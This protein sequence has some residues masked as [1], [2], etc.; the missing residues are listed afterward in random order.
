MEWMRYLIQTPDQKLNKDS[1]I[2]RERVRNREAEMKKL[3]MSEPSLFLSV[4]QQQY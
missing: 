4:K 1:N 2:K 3:E